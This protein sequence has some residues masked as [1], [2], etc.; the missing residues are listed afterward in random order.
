MGGRTGGHDHCHQPV[1][2]PVSRHRLRRAIR[3]FSPKPASIRGGRVRVTETSVL[4][5]AETV[6]R[7]LQLERELGVRVAIDDF[8][9]GYSSLVHLKRLPIDTLKIDQSFIATSP[10]SGRQ[11]DH[12]GDHRA[13]AQPGARCRRRRRQSAEQLAFLTERGCDYYQGTTSA[14]R[15][16]GAFIALVS[17][18]SASAAAGLEPTPIS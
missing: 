2:A 4:Y 17:A 10:G 12:R 11:G 9:T 1:G 14:N 15:W 7:V 6:G 3:R 5:D 18:T 13:G 16:I 8:G